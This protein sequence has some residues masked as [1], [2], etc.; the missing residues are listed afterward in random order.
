MTG[1]AVRG[2]VSRRLLLA[3][4]PVRRGR[5]STPAR[6]RTQAL[7]AVVLAC[8]LAALTAVL[9]VQLQ[10]D[11]SAIGQRDA[12][13]ADATTGLYF[14]LNDMD[15]QVANV[16]LV[17]GDTTLAAD[18]TQDMAIYASDR[19]AADADLQQA[20]AGEADNAAAERQL[21]LVL[22]RIGQYETLAADALL[23]SQESHSAAGHAPAAAI[24]YYRQAT[25]LMQ[26]GI[27]P[28][29]GSLSTVSAT[30]LDAAYGAGKSASGTG[31]AL[32]V[33]VGALLAARPW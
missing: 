26:S 20:T 8:C 21:G 33:A 17:G 29:V 24:A 12:Q 23:T 14:A 30:R 31:T 1:L 16:L 25:S 27:L 15:A 4:P 19:T 3:R 28:A 18:R 32:V 6:L 5:L 9:F 13:E 7:A 22:D 10:G 11:F 2:G